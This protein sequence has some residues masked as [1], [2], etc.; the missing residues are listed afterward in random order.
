MKKIFLLFGLLFIIIAASIFIQNY[1]KTNNTLLFGKNPSI[2]INNQTFKLSLAKTSQE[3]EVGLST[4][5]SLP[6]D[7]GMLFIFE[8]PDYY[9]FWMKNMKFP[10]DIIY[11]NNDQIVAIHKNLKPPTNPN[12]AAVIY[13]PQEP[14]SKVLEINAGLS[15]KYDFKKGDKVKI[16]NL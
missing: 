12:D 7:Q 1:F 5:E 3:K 10:I 14:A 6:E 13:T 9:P 11:I 4:T 2:K 16:D 8:K 15:E